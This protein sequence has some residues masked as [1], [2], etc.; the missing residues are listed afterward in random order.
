[1]C[2]FDPHPIRHGFSSFFPFVA[3]LAA[4]LLSLPTPA[5]GKLWSP[6]QDPTD[7]AKLMSKVADGDIIEIPKGRWYGPIHVKKSVVLRGKGGIIDGRQKGKV[8]VVTAARVVL[9]GLIVQG[10]GTDL[11]GPDSCI[12]LA[13]SA[14][15]SIVRKNLIR[16]C[17]F[18][19]WLHEANYVQ[20]LGNRVIGRKDITESDRGN[21]IHLFDGSYLLVRKNHVSYARDGIY[22]SAVEDSLIE[23]N[24]LSH[25]RYGVHYMFSYRNKLLRNQSVH[26]LTGLALMQ[27]HHLHVEGNIVKHN[28]RHGI[29]F[30]DAQYCAIK[31]NILHDNGEGMFFFSSNDNVIEENILQHN[32]VGARIWAGTYRNRV[33]KNAFLYNAQQIFFVGSSDLHWGQGKDI[34]NYWSDYMGWDQNKDGIGDRP[35]RLDNFTSR[36]L[37]QYP[38]SVLLMRSPSLELLSHLEQRLPLLRVATVIDHRPLMRW[39]AKTASF[40]HSKRQQRML[41]RK[42]RR[43]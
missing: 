12:Y 14:E 16:D 42:E 30:R 27:S 11:G 6:S 22:V 35:Y 38:S 18:G 1:M 43:R 33:Q 32:R 15:R 40:F 21:G 20:I 24:Y 9:E 36:L 4:C 8:I 5:E 28:Q 39:K 34:G 26:N 13:K 25:Q 37:Y 10:S 29:L 31:K 19:L 2:N 7:L 17:A 3:W 23:E 41:K